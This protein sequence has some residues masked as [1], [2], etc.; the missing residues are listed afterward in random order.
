MKKHQFRITLEHTADKD[1]TPV[2]TAPLTF[3]APNHDNIFDIIG[4]M[5]EREGFTPE[6]AQRFAVGLKLM[7]EVMMENKD[8]PL[9]AE[10]KPHFMEMMKVIKGKK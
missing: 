9:F 2:L 8:N 4:L 1:G 5:Q 7:G 10:L 6:M 3:D